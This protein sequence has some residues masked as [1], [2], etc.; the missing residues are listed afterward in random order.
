M[1]FTHVVGSLL[2]CSLWKPQMM[3][4]GTS[5]GPTPPPPSR[6]SL[7]WFQ[8]LRSGPWG[9][10]LPQTWQPSATR[11]AEEGR[12]EGGNI[13]MVASIPPALLP[14]RRLEC[15]HFLLNLSV[16]LTLPVLGFILGFTNIRLHSVNWVLFSIQLN[17]TSPAPK[18][19]WPF[20]TFE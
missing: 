17:K 9:R 15:C 2:S 14:R 4:F 10:N 13:L 16:L 12:K 7:L 5:S 19:R 3:P 18:L 11:W 6:T 20:L 8:P 1:L